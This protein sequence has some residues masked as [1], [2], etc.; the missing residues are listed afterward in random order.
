MEGKWGP[1]HN[2][3]RGKCPKVPVRAGSVNP[4]VFRGREGEWEVLCYGRSGGGRESGKYCVMGVEECVRYLSRH[5][6]EAPDQRYHC[7]NCGKDITLRLKCA[8]C[9]DCDL[10]LDVRALA[11]RAT[12]FTVLVTWQI[13]SVPTYNLLNCSVS[14][15]GLKW[16]YTVVTM[17]TRSL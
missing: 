4:T 7:A 1:H 12:V 6:D 2:L 13:K 9:Q 17:T 16:A 14:L 8:E 5:A 11:L 15:G 10:C 3:S